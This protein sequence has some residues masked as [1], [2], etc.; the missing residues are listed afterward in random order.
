MR[1]MSAW[2]QTRPFGDVR[3]MS[4]LLP[5]AAVEPT[6]MDGRE[7]PIADSCIAT[8]EEHGCNYLLDHLIGKE[9]KL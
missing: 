6:S 8:N 5:K 2:G 9:L 1:F 3:S 7:V 4:G